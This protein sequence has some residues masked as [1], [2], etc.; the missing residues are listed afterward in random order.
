MIVL[1][2]VLVLDHYFVI[3]STP[4]DDTC[5][6]T[7]LDKKFVHRQMAKLPSHTTP[8]LSE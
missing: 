8:H 7:D 4:Y 5:T 1:V 3:G 2:L 6:L